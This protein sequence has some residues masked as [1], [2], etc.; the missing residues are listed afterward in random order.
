MARASK[1]LRRQPGSRQE[2]QTYLICSEG[3]NTE[4]LYFKGLRRELRASNVRI[5]VTSGQGEPYGV[6]EKAIAEVERATASGND[7]D[8]VFCVIDVEAPPT[9]THARLD[10]ALRLAARHGIICVVSNPCFELYLLLHYQD[11]SAYLTT[12]EAG[13]LLE[14][15][16]CGYR[17]RGKLLN[18]EALQPGRAEAH[19][20]AARLDR[21][22][23]GQPVPARNPWTSVPDLVTEL[24][25]AAARHP[26]RPH[27]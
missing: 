20:R 22:H 17:R 8:R 24:E 14:K 1:P 5:V 19:R 21:S 3:K 11:V 25:S 6:V 15:H 18:F 10:A 7:Y 13:R 4:T 23:A 9:H 26:Q 27:A 16:P 2:R 12:E